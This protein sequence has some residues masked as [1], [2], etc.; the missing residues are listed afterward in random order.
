MIE[1]IQFA[2]KDKKFNCINHE[3]KGPKDEND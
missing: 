3:Y 2:L 1:T